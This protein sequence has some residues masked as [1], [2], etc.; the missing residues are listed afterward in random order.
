MIHCSLLCDWHM[1]RRRES[2][3]YMSHFLT[4]CFYWQILYGYLPK[5]LT[6]KIEWPFFNNFSFSDSMHVVRFHQLRTNNSNNILIEKVSVRI[7]NMETKFL[8]QYFDHCLFLEKCALFHKYFYKRATC[9]CVVTAA[10][11]SILQFGNE[12]EELTFWKI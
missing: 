7:N 2:K 12:L 1:H 8:W 4:Y 11:S 10:D 9:A 3:V 6:I 5:L